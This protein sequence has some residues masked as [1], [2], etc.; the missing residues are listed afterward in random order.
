[1]RTITL[2]L[3]RHGPPHN[4]LLSPLTQ[5]L[6]LCEN[7]AAITI[8]V[9]FEHNP[10]L[11]RLLALAY[12]QDDR[13]REFQLQDTARELGDLLGKIPGL[14][15][16]LNRE[17]PGKERSCNGAEAERLTHLRLVISASELALL[18][19]ELAL[20][21]NGFPGAGQHLLMQSQDPICLTREVRRVAEQWV[22]S[23]E[24]PRILLAAASPA[25][26]VPLEAHVQALRE[27]IDPWVRHFQTEDERRRRIEEHLVVLPQA[28][29]HALQHAC[30]T[31]G[32]T[33]VHVLAHGVQY[34][35]GYDVRYGLAFHDE[36][37]PDKVD[38]VTGTRLA[39]IL[40]ASRHEEALARGQPGASAPG[41]EDGLARP[42]AVTLASCDSGNVGTI[43]G[44]GASVAHALHEAGI[45]MVVGSQFPLSFEGS[46]RMVDVLYD[47]LLWGEDPRV[48]MSDL[49]RRLL[50]EFPQRHDWAT[51]TTYAS[52][53][54]QL[55][56]ELLDVR[57]AQSMRAINVAMSHADH[58]TAQLEPRTSRRR[59]AATPSPDVRALLER[60]REKIE[61]AKVR[62]ERLAA[63][64]PR[65]RARL[66]GL[67]ASTEK[68]RAEVYF[69]FSRTPGGDQARDRAAALEGLRCA[70]RYY[71]RTY[72]LERGSSWALV[73]Y[74][75][76]D[77][78]LRT[79]PDPDAD[80][81]PRAVPEHR[82]PEALWSLANVLSH[83][84]LGSRRPKRAV[85]A[86]GNLVELE[87]LA[88]LWKPDEPRPTQLA[89]DE[90]AARARAL[91]WSRELADRGGPESFEVYST[92]RQLLRYVEWFPEMFSD[93][94]V[95]ELRSTAEAVL[96]ALPEAEERDW[97]T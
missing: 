92:R 46:I 55:E 10:F 91:E 83:E 49:R 19:F 12:R 30:A 65:Q 84:D 23:P 31:G 29:A 18:P 42:V 51:L 48:L 14:I 25:G 28:T 97:S 47:G 63:R 15:A 44:M 82:R 56:R 78:L 67:L 95:A 87:L 4:Q 27:A 9:P 81:A 3:L 13:S 88:I 80:G 64:A 86:L 93:P 53:P 22:R 11:H 75:A 79:Q 68:R 60:A 52:L 71:W 85:W 39:T 40:R 76:L 2:E 59:K 90:A 26:S 50:S 57:I 36:R 1:M 94:R 34:T 89:K 62:L 35:E 70:R 32:Y 74:L 66:Y 21:P 20:A 54:P 58:A 73:Q 96:E 6:A 77:L 8:Q 16:E 37:D 7:H 33:H 45:P 24:K 43:G 61:T 72:Q 5:Y 41:R 69:S 17:P 38:I